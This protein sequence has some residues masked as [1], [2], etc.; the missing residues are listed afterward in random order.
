MG[1][2]G[3]AGGVTKNSKVIHGQHYRAF[4]TE[5]TNMQ[6]LRAS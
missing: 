1:S 3:L 4:G 2:A 5:L 6:G